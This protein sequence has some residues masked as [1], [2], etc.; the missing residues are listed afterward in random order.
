MRNICHKCLYHGR[1]MMYRYNNIQTKYMKKVDRLKNR[2]GNIVIY[3]EKCSKF[4]E[5]K[6]KHSLEKLT[7]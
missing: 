7:K 6:F 2:D 5:R 4:T 3:V 1:C